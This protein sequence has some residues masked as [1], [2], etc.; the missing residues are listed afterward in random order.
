MAKK[1]NS[2][3]IVGAGISGLIAA[4]VL[5]KNGYAPKIIEATNSVGGRV[6]TD[7]KDG[8]ILDHGFQ[9]LL[10]AYPKAKEYLDFKALSLNKFVSGAAIFKNG[11]QKILGDPTR[12]FSLAMPTLFSGI[13]NFKDKILILKLNNT[14]K[15][16]S[17][18]A[19]FNAEEQTTL[20]YL[21]EKGFSQEIINDFFKP[22]FT[23]IFLESKLDTSSR[24]FEF[25]YKMFGEGLAVI[26]AKGI[27]AISNQLANQLEKT[28]ISF[29]SRVKKIE[30]NTLILTNGEELNY[31]A[32]IL[33]TD[34]K[35]IGEK[36]TAKIKWKGCDNLYYKT[37]NAVLKKPIIGL[38]ADKDALINNIYYPSVFQASASQTNSYIS[39]T[40]VKNHEL[41]NEQLQKQVALEL[42]KYCGIKVTD[43]I[44]HYPIKMALPDLTNLSYD[45]K[46]ETTHLGEGIFQAGDILLNGSLN[47]AMISGERAAEAVADYLA[48]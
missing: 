48:K 17:L 1:E 15:K 45:L 35:N 31:D 2:I 16:K 20:S 34:P 14:L 27:G 13:G 21:Q 6:K 36:K 12:D 43:F 24:M 39:V 9:V 3:C 28:T 8:Y 37:P 42:E 23:G 38:I 30:N 25:V 32:V 29:E 41:T 22:F 19:I 33:A 18:E 7:V 26:P 4:Q 5:E 46:P 44:A 47:A 10:D 11:K 40:V